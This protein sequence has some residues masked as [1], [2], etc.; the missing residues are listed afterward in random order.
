MKDRYNILRAIGV[1]VFSV[2]AVT[3]WSHDSDNDTAS[4]TQS[5]T[6]TVNS[7]DQ[8][9]INNKYGQVVVNTWD[10]DSL[11]ITVRLTA[12]G[13][14]YLEASKTL[15]RIDV[16]LEKSG[17]I[18]N[19]ETVFDRSSGFLSEVWKTLND[20][21]R[22][23][24]SKSKLEINYQVNAP[25]SLKI[26]VSNKFGDIY[27]TDVYSRLQIDLMYGNFRVNQINARSEINVTSGNVKIKSMKNG[28]LELKGTDTDIQKAEEIEINSS[29]STIRIIEAVSIRYDGKGDKSLRVDE[30]SDIS[31]KVSF[32]D[33][34]VGLLKKRVNLNMN[35]TDLR[36]EAVQFN[37]E[38]IDI[39][40]KSS[41]INLELPKNS[42]ME[43]DLEGR[44]DR[45][46]LP[47]EF[48]VLEKQVV[49]EKKGDIRLSGTVGSSSNYKT[50]LRINADGGEIDIR[51]S[52]E[53]EK[54]SVKK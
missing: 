35:Y 12:Y 37:F 10:R 48:K 18:I 34:T 38:G 1:F 22:A 36:I 43:I 47:L 15:D 7:G 2:L 45:M 42:F 30:I 50:T 44:D 21:S 13:K 41:D 17:Q 27:M 4:R 23:L 19:A 54:T 26:N 6:F 53:T 9:N 31:G 49:D 5:K 20:D 24:L 25:K 33:I 28:Q 16:D 29:S 11:S 46:F 40:G 52:K 3:G 32:S 8:L 14:T 39:T 51:W